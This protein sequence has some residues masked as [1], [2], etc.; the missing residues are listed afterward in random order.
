MEKFMF[1][2]YKLYF[3]FFYVEIE[4]LNI[5][6]YDYK[7]IWKIVIFKCWVN[8]CLFYKIFYEVSLILKMSC[9]YVLLYII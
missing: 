6:I 5:F 4:K 2:L 9:K 3:Y 7:Y 1:N 8:K